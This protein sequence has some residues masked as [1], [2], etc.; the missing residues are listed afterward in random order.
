MNISD[1]F[2]V[3]EFKKLMI[4]LKEKE[5]QN[6]SLADIIYQIEKEILNIYVS[7]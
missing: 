1:H 4:T 7:K 5:T 2:T 3:K 6:L